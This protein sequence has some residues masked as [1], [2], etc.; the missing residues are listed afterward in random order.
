MYPIFYNDICFSNKNQMRVFTLFFLILFYLFSTTAQPLHHEIIAKVNIAEKSIQ[1]NDRITFN[2]TMQEVP[3]N[4]EFRLNKKLQF[5]SLR[6]VNFRI[7]LAN[8]EDPD[9][10]IYSMEIIE[11]SGKLITVDLNYQGTI[12]GNIEK[13]KYDYSR[14]F[15]ETKGIISDNGVYLAGSTFWIPEFTTYSSLFSFTL[16]VEIAKEWNVMSQGE[17]TFNRIS[18]EV[19]IVKYVCENPMDEVY[20]V[21]SQWT[22]YADSCGNVLVQ[23]FLRK[24]DNELAERYKKVTCNYLS[25]YENL[26]GP[27]P[28]SKFALV[29]NFWETG[30]G[31]PSFTLLGEKVIRFPWILHSSYPHELLHNYWG[32][33]V[34]VDYS[35]GNWCEG[36]TAYMADHLIKERNGE[37]NEYR[38]STLQKYADFV[39]PSNEITLSTFINRNSPAEEA[40]GYGKCLMM[41]HMLRMKLGD[42]VFLKA[43]ADFYKNHIYTTASYNDIKASFQPFVSEDL[44]PF[45]EQWVNQKGAPSIQL[46]NV[47]VR[48]END[49]FTLLFN[50]SQVQKN[51]TFDID[52]P[53]VVYLEDKMDVFQCTVNLQDRSKQFIFKFKERPLKIEIDPEFDVFRLLDKGE[54]PASLSRMYGSQTITIILPKGDPNYYDYEN[55]AN[56]WKKNFTSEGKKVD[57]ITDRDLS[58]LPSS[59]AIWIFGF[60]NKF[61]VYNQI[62]EKLI[63]TLDTNLKTKWKAAQ[64]S[65]I[66]VFVYS[67]PENIQQTF[68][69][70]GLNNFEAMSGFTARLPHY[71][72]YSYLGFQGKLPANTFNGVWPVINSPLSYTFKFANGQPPVKAKLPQRKALGD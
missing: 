39:N 30:Y 54:V 16:Q 21:A 4:I 10:N 53:V 58:N 68:A 57:I 36:I 23:S 6:G 9:F 24:A 35:Q 45:F 22:E 27:Y 47:H 26:I 66:L 64:D 62:A 14:G 51:D 34:Y 65:G 50:L 44:T 13:S 18:N 63:E 29:E 60:K 67:N 3:A 71:S 20:L 7:T 28:F 61:A 11:I 37:G 2:D 59:S 48:N 38:R 42:E 41:N 12:E 25:L 5:E 69:F 46:S 33:S 72:K 40:I 43:Y 17:R 70:A 52:L 49:S 31:M 15:S 56:D 19:R 8:S 1:V 32:N 55:M